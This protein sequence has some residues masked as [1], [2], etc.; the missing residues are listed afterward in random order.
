[1]RVRSNGREAV[2]GSSLRGVVARIASKHATVIGEMAASEAPLIIT[3]AAPSMIRS[4]AWPS[5]SMPEVQPVEMTPTG[6]C[7]SASQ[8]SSAAMEEGAK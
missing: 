4:A 6:P 5:T 2:A 3:S 1:M 8:A 7:A